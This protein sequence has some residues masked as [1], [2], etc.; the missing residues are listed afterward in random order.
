MRCIGP[1]RATYTGSTYMTH[2]HAHTHTHTHIRKVVRSG[3]G[4]NMHTYMQTCSTC[5]RAYRTYTHTHTLHYTH[6][7]PK[8]AIG[9]RKRQQQQ[10]YWPLSR[11]LLLKKRRRGSK[12]GRRRR[13]RSAINSTNFFFFFF[14]FFFFWKCFTQRCSDRRRAQKCP[15]KQSGGAKNASR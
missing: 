14:F 10:L 4:F 3:A 13:R 2:T 11:V 15:C 5:L 7:H 12:R 9:N 8:T 6:T 1:G